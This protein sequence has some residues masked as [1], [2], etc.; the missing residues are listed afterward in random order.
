L[1]TWTRGAFRVEYEPSALEHN[2]DTPTAGLLLEAA[3]RE[4][5][6]GAR[7]SA[8]EPIPPERALLIES[9]VEPGFFAAAGDDE[10][11]DDDVTGAVKRAPAGVDS[12]VIDVEHTPSERTATEMQGALSPR[13]I[14]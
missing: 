14:P 4:D 2:I 11:D 8:S 6:A 13:R 5:E 9:S 3:R 7:F 10:R 1:V 12:G